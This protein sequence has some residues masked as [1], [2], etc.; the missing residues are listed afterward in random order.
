MRER[1]NVSLP[2]TI[3]AGYRSRLID[4]KVIDP[5]DGY[6]YYS[7]DPKDY[8]GQEENNRPLDSYAQ[9]DIFFKEFR[10]HR[11]RK[12]AEKTKNLYFI[13]D[14][15]MSM[16]SVHTEEL[17]QLALSNELIGKSSVESSDRFTH[18]KISGSS[19][20]EVAFKSD[21]LDSSKD[22]ERIELVDR[23]LSCYEEAIHYMEG[24]MK[25]DPHYI[26]YSVDV[27]R[28]KLQLA[29]EN[30]YKDIVTRE[31]TPETVSEIREMLKGA[32]KESTHMA[33]THGLSNKQRTNHFGYGGELISLSKI[34]DSYQ[35][36]GDPIAIPSSERGGSGIFGGFNTHDI[37]T[38]HQKRTFGRWKNI[39]PYEVKRR[40]IT[41]KMTDRYL[42]PIIQVHRNQE[43]EI[44]QPNRKIDPEH[45][46]S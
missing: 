15:K 23:G 14:K 40:K 22:D 5:D 45:E 41:K 16:R 38:M 18:L 31:L 10:A 30:V 21:D 3:P 42:S 26:R 12:A 17:L 7:L 1:D 27:E 36:V 11:E 44:H 19:Y 25:R 29:F 6:V 34:W 43:I 20:I 13:F 4:H 46:V 32:I 33:Q 35:K 37:V 24:K 39:Q 8:E 9:T 28:A 2:F